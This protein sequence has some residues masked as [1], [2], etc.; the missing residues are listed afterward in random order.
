MDMAIRK[1]ALVLAAVSV[2]AAVAVPVVADELDPAPQEATFSILDRPQTSA[3]ELPSEMRAGLVDSYAESRAA[4][5]TIG[6]LDGM[7]YWAAP[8]RVVGEEQAMICVFDYDARYGTSGVAC[9]PRADAAKGFYLASD[10]E[11][12]QVVAVLAA[13]G[14][15]AVRTP[16]GTRDLVENATVVALS[17]PGTLEFVGTPD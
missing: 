13:D 12:H 5:R 15:D 16:T 10:R 14:V 3:D 2:S 17:S 7:H 6:E 1:L 11:D 8:G 4:L 9:N